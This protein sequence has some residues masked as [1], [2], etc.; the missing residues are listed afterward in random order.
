MQGC[1]EQEA[2]GLREEPHMPES[3]VAGAIESNLGG[4]GG[5][6]QKGRL[7][8]ERGGNRPWVAVTWGHL[9]RMLA[10]VSPSHCL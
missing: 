6:C 9:G 8:G 2:E 10:A 4:T 5:R 3:M 7:C 1:E